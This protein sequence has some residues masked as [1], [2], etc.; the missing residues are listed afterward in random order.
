MT[1]ATSSFVITSH[2]PSEASATNCCPPYAGSVPRRWP[3]YPISVPVSSAPYLRVLAPNAAYLGL[4]RD[5]VLQFGIANRLVAL[6][7]A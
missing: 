1:A 3:P 2:T 4:R 6:V 5:Q 7:A